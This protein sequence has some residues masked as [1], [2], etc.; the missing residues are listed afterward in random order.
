ML[1]KILFVDDDANILAAFQRQLRKFFAVE[2]ALGAKEG[3]AAVAD[4]GPFSVIVSDFRMPG[5]DGI[6]FLSR[7]RENAPDSVRMMLTGNADLQTAIDAVNEGNIFRFLT[8][9]CESQVFAKALLAGVRQHSLVTAEK[10]LLE[11]TL[12]GSIKVLCEILQLLN[13][14][15][16]GRASRI[17]HYVKAIGKRMRVADMWQLETAAALSQI[18]CVILPEAALKKLYQGRELT[19]EESQL[20]S[21][22]P[23]IASDLLVHIPRMQAIAEVIANQQKNFDGSGIPMDSCSGKDIPL[24]ARILKVVL[25]FDTLQVKG[26][27]KSESAEQ[28]AAKN[29]L[30]DPEVLSALVEVIEIE[31]GYL[32]ASLKVTQL[33]DQMVL[34]E[35]VLL[36]DGR[37]LAARGYKINRTLRQRLGS[38]AERPGIREPI[39]V[40]IPTQSQCGA[41]IEVIAEDEG[42]AL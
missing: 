21:M 42:H 31:A 23:S 28:L 10:E 37:L 33:R 30:Y 22:H 19:G 11:K 26:A 17:T 36:L 41:E 25:D 13:P 14:E 4:R 20:F 6:Q 34:S 29:G 38:F 40:L 35:D 24:G 2:T 15:A 7:V 5:M 16:F 18:G 8:K 1:P 3:L 32:K 12:R 39:S 9:P 27:S